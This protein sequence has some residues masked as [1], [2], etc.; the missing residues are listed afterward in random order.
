MD[1]ADIERQADVLH[2]QLRIWQADDPIRMLAPQIVTEELGYTFEEVPSLDWPP[3]KNGTSYGGQIDRRA[4][5]ITIATRF[6]P[7][8]QRF[9]GI[10]EVGHLVLHGKYETALFHRDIPLSGAER[11]KQRPLIEREADCFAGFYL[12]PRRLLEQ[13]MELRFGRS[14]LEGI[15]WDDGLAFHLDSRNHHELVV[16]GNDG[17]RGRSMAIAKATSIGQRHFR[18]LSEVFS[19]STIAMAIQLE[20]T[21]LVS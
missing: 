21:G 17:K 8:V 13:H 1:R 10:H 20:L 6:S 7:V 3:G 2:R 16:P 18:S 11:S 15:N 5:R 19:V 14:S 4:E 12:I 9:T